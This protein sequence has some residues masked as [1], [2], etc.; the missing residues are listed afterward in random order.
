MD[1]GS[2]HGTGDPERP[3]RETPRRDLAGAMERQYRWCAQYRQ[4]CGD[5]GLS[6]PDLLGA[7]RGGDLLAL[8]ALGTDS[9]KRSRGLFQALADRTVPGSWM[10]SS[11]TGGDPSYRW[12][13]P[14]DLEYSAQSFGDA[15]RKVPDPDVLLLLTPP[16]EFLAVMGR[17]AAIDSAETALWV[18]VPTRTALARSR[19]LSFFRPGPDTGGPLALRREALVQA[20]REAEEGGSRVVLAYSVILIREA[21]EALAGTSFDFGDRIFVVTGGGGWEGGKGGMGGRPVE[22]AKYI[23]ALAATFG[24]S[25]PGKQVVDIYGS[26]ELG[27]FHAGCWS[28][29][30]GDFVFTVTPDVTLFLIDPGSGEPV[31][32]GAR[33]LPR[34]ISPAGVRGS[35]T[36]V[37]EQEGDSMVPVSRAP[38]GSVREYTGISRARRT[39][40]GDLRAW[41]EHEWDGCPVDLAQMVAKHLFE[42]TGLP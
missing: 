1:G 7:A 26:A 23:S 6:L 41:L 22:K 4:L 25:D 39:G 28:P 34:F 38:D 19:S 11:A 33:G 29:H 31:E 21:L 10:V 36:A 32:D 2:G 9:W 18:S 13:T 14:D 16:P 20:L 24:I 42:D 40:P 5:R 12:C 3:P 30:A 27:K 17:R 35:A 8:P 15:Y 37:I